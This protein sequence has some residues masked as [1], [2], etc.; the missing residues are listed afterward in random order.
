MAYGDDK[1]IANYLANRPNVN[2]KIGN[3]TPAFTGYGY[4]LLVVHADPSAERHRIKLDDLYH[5][6][7]ADSKT[8]DESEGF[9]DQFIAA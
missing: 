3:I 1:E 4:S 6:L 7:V 9:G 2:N 5:K 8:D